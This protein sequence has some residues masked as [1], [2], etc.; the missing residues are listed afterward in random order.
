SAYEHQD[1][2]FEQLVDHLK[3]ERELNRNPV[4]QVMFGLHNARGDQ[5]IY[6]SGMEVSPLQ[7]E[8]YISKVDLTITAIEEGEDAIWVGVEYSRDLFDE[9]TIAQMASHYEQCLDILSETPKLQ[10]REFD[11]LTREERD[12]QLIEWNKTKVNYAEEGQTVISLFEQ[13]AEKTPEAIALMYE[14][15]QLSYRALNVRANQLAR[16]L[17]DL[18]V[19][20]ESLVGICLER[21]LDLIVS[22]L[23]VHKAGGAYLPLESTYPEE[24]LQYILDDTKTPIILADRKTYD[25]LPTTL[26]QVICLENIEDYLKTLSSANVDYVFSPCNLAYVIYT[27]GSTGQ[28]KGVMLSH[29]NL[30]HYI[31]YTQ[32]A[33]S[34]ARGTTIL[35]SSFAFDMSI[36]SIFLPLIE[37]NSIH[38]LPEDSSVDSL[39]G[40][41]R[42]HNNNLSFIKVTPTHLK[43]LKSQ[44]SLEHIHGQKSGLIIGGENLLK[45]DIKPWLNAKEGI[46]IF[47]EYGPTETTVGCCVFKVKS[48]YESSSDSVPIGRPI[49]NTQLYILDQDLNP[50]PIGVTGELYIGGV[51]LARGYLNRPDLTAE[52]FIP[53]PFSEEGGARLYRTGDLARYLP[54]GNIEYV[55]RVDHQVKIRGYRIELGEIESVLRRYHSIE[56]VVVIVQEDGDNKY[57]IAYLVNSEKAS[58]PEE[59]GQYIDEAR[60][61]LKERLPDYMVPSYF[62]VLPELPLSSNGKIDRKALPALDKEQRQ[63][64]QTYEAPSNETEKKLADIW[65]TLLQ[66]ETIG[67][68]DNF[69]ALGGHSLLGIQLMSRIR[70]AFSKNI[71]LKN[72]F[73][74]PT[75]AGLAKVLGGKEEKTR[76]A[77]PITPSGEIKDIPLSFAQQ[78]LWFIDQLLPN[79]NLYNVPIAL[80]LRGKLNIEALEKAFSSLVERHEILRTHFTASDDG[81]AYQVIEEAHEIRLIKEDFSHIHDVEQERCLKEEAEKEASQPF[82]LSQGPLLRVRVLHLGKEDY[83]LLITLHHIVIDAWSLGI[84]FRELGGYYESYTDGKA[85]SIERLP[86]QYKDFAVWQRNWLQGE[87]LEKQLHYWQNRLEGAPDQI[88]LPTDRPRPKEMSYRGGLYRGKIEGSVVKRLRAL[89]QEKN[90]SLFMVLLAAFQVLLHRYSGQDDIVVGSP[91]A[92]RHYKEI[93]GLIGFF[94]NTLAYRSFYTENQNFEDY[95]L[96][97]RNSTLS[98]YEHQDVPF[99]QLVDYLKIEREPNRN[100]IFQVLFGFQQAQSM[101]LNNLNINSV[102]LGHYISKFDLSVTAVEDKEDVV[103]F[104]CEYS[105]D[106][107]NEKT[108]AQL[109]THYERC[110]DILSENTKLQLREYDIL[111]EEERHQQLIEWN[112]T[113]VNYAKKKQTIIPLIEQQVE[114]TP[115]AIALMYE[116]EQLSYRALNARANQLAWYLREQGV[117]PECLVGVCLGRSLDL[118]ITILAVLK[119]GGAYVP[120]DPEYPKERLQ[121]ILNDSAVKVLLTESSL[122]ARFDEFEGQNVLL[123]RIQ[124]EVQQKSNKNLAINS[125]LHQLAYVIYT[126]G[127]TGRPKGVAIEQKSFCNLALTQIKYFEI[128]HFSRVLQFASANFDASVSEWSTALLS[129]ATLYI[130]KD[131]HKD[132]SAKFKGFLDQYCITH[133]TLPPSLVKLISNDGGL[134]HP[135]TIVLAG[136][137]GD[138]LIVDAWKDSINLINAYGPTEATV[139]A[140]VLKN[141]LDYSACT[142]GKPIWNTQLYILDAYGRLVPQGVIG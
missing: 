70:Q 9:K 34:L 40:V 113:K 38:I 32:R 92:N 73:E 110:L 78:R 79:S 128:N 27:S 21:S 126:S 7:L 41:L 44:L 108:I 68:H 125:F 96:Q 22:I 20:P 75:V 97:T 93:E 105:E 129:G 119:V 101:K 140:S 116:G 60:S 106:L 63:V 36:T 100:P 57:L 99:E 112:N 43:V 71:T 26:A 103:W 58:L 80:R 124:G 12:K 85:L 94:V 35:H 135:K 45:E 5:P 37:G 48:D 86:I 67:V 127:S 3:I 104:E 118:I 18:G 141:F 91:V 83:A 10:L 74:N 54:D 114:K 24:R 2:P 90:C 6:L 102:N 89:A 30:S 81:Q 13:Q 142:I 136:E 122:S 1:V 109:S 111:S 66:V 84:F 8:R 55:G 23:A 98:A 52:R 69:F 133:V 29:G 88:K 123:D 51:G 15:K 76:T 115:D 31:K 61:Y 49:D 17:Q 138:Q 139:C 130:P 28:P 47:N 42:E 87:E 50:L 120:L 82:D 19:G 121:F 137:A 131:Q 25:E 72:L 64:G 16:Y 14:G 56:D 65:S 134:S 4:F 107:F 62:M 33:Y 132:L 39:G 53:A 95:L 59:Q 46:P 11:I 117:G 77:P